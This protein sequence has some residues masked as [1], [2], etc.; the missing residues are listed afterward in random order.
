MP[1]RLSAPRS[2]GC[3]AGA[4]CTREREPSHEHRSAPG[5]QGLT[6]LKGKAV[7]GYVITV[8]ATLFLPRAAQQDGLDARTRAEP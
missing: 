5:I 7:G 2:G 6:D 8:D 1:A 3:C 4:T